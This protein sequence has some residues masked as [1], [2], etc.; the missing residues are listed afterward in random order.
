MVTYYPDEPA[1]PMFDLVFTCGVLIHIPPDDLK[2]VMQGLIDSSVGYVL[3][4]EYEAKEETEVEYRGHK[5]KLWKRDYG[6]LYQELG[7]ELVEKGFLLEFDNC[8]YW[9]MRKP[10]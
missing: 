6:K 1:A 3:A 7:L 10:L 9:L 2:Q 8:T 5:G 4:I